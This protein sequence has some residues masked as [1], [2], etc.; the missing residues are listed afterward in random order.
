MRAGNDG[1]NEQD[2]QD[3]SSNE[4]SSFPV[5]DHQRVVGFAP[6]QGDMQLLQSKGRLNYSDKHLED[7]D[8]AYGAMPK[9]SFDK[10]STAS[11]IVGMCF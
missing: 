8:G 4:V 5:H 11:D 3:V 2:I 9:Q 6:P 1:D 7:L 10:P